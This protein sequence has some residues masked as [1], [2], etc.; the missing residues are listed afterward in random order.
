MK[1]LLKYAMLTLPAIVIGLAWLE[2]GATSVLVTLG[3]LLLIGLLAAAFITG[4]EWTRRTM[5][6]GA[7][8]RLSPD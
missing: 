1:R 4:A 5:R 6:L 2:Y 8:K 7:G 3:T